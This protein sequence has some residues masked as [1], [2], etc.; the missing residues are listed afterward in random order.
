MKIKNQGKGI[1][2]GG[3]KVIVRQNSAGQF[4]MTIPRGLAEIILL[5]DKDI[6]SFKVNNRDSLIVTKEKMTLEEYK[7]LKKQQQ[8]IKN[9]LK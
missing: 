3:N 2:L 6:V 4:N 5:Q 8:D 9:Q 1:K 7:V